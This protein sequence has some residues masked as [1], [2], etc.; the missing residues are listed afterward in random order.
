MLARA[1]ED[2]SVEPPTDRYLAVFRDW[3]DRGLTREQTSAL[4][5][6]HGFAPQAAGAWSR[7][8]WIKI[9]DDGFRYLTERSHAWV[10]ERGQSE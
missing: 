9:A 4:L 3:S 1:I 7:D 8:D 10:K 6:K 2:E 5:R